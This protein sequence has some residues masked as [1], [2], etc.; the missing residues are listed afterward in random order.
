[1][2]TFQTKVLFTDLLV[3]GRAVYG[4]DRLR[5]RDERVEYVHRHVQAIREQ[6]T[7]LEQSVPLRDEIAVIGPEAGK[8]PVQL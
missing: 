6:M 4:I 2:N 8:A 5:E 3:E 7:A 1:M